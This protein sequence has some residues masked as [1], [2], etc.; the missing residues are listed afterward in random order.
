M[1]RQLA[2][3][4]LLP[5]LATG[6]T[7]TRTYQTTSWDEPHGGWERPG[8]VERVRE[9]VTRTE[10]NPAGGAVAGALIGGLLGSAIGGH[11]HYDR[12]G[13][14]YHHASGAG[15]VFGAVGGAMVGAAASQGSSEDRTYEVLVRFNDGGRQRFVYR[16]APPFR[17]GDEVLLTDRGLQ[18]WGAAG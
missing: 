8:R 3:L 15:A 10:G 4:L 12:W 18:P 1:T 11:T 17:A 14:A 5:L 7:T 9:T 6:C 16:G 13:R 2:A